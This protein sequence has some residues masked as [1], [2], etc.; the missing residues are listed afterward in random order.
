MKSGDLV[1]IV[2]MPKYWGNADLKGKFG[3]VIEKGGHD[4]R[5]I[6]F[7]DGRKVSFHRNHLAVPSDDER[8]RSL[9]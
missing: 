6:V 9:P 1:R 7:V 4:E 8:E 3:T 5:W 2:K